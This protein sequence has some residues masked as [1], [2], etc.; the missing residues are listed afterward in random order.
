[1][2]VTYTTATKIARMDAVKA[3]IDAGT[4]AGKLEIGTAGMATVLATIAL[5]D[6]CGTSSDTG[7]GVVKLTFSGMPRSDTSADATGT[8]AAAR[9]RDSN[10]TDVITGLTV[11]TS[12]TDIILDSTSITAGQTVTISAATIQHA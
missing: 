6:P 10:N 8:A 3:Q 1:M 7:G 4:G 11:G 5:N 9:I 2:A 12:G